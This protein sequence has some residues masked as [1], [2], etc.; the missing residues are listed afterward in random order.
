MILELSIYY[1]VDILNSA[2]K[3]TDTADMY[4]TVVPSPAARRTVKVHNLV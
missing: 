2:S 1:I 3:N 4:S